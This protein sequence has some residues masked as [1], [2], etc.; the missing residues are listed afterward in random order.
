MSTVTV[1][2]LTRVAPLDGLRGIAIL[3]VVLHNTVAAVVPATPDHLARFLGRVAAP[4]WIGVQL[5]FALSGCLIAGELLDHQGA[6]NYLRAF[7]ARRALRIL[8]LYYSTLALVAVMSALLAMPSVVPVSR[9]EGWQLGLFVNNYARP[10]PGGF[11][12]FWSLAVEVQFYALAPWVVWRIRAP[13]LALA[14]VCVAVGVLVVRTICAEAG[15]GV[16]TLY[17][18]TIFR[19]DA[20]ALGAAGA[21]C[22]RIESVANL[23][24]RHSATGALLASVILLFGASTTHAYNYSSFACETFGYTLAALACALVV[25]CAG[26]ARMNGEP[27]R[28]WL[29]W[30]SV[31]PLR[32]IGRYSFGIYLFHGLLNHLAGVPLARHLFRTPLSGEMILGYCAAVFIASFILAALSFELFESRFLKLKPR[33]EAHPA[34]TDPASTGAGTG[35]ASTL[36]KT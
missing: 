22:V 15:A 26:A 30:L 19:L 28:R 10:P 17:T 6:R 14:C 7:Y 9:D 11:A 33:F 13:R 1:R 24:R 5:F 31:S 35:L 23:L 8:P 4:G 32:L 12:H 29:R 16:W 18:G 27:Q 20:L 36:A 21:C 2:P 3:A 34:A 25:A